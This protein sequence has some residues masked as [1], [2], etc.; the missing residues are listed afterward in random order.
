MSLYFVFIFQNVDD[1]HLTESPIKKIRLSSLSSGTARQDQY[2]NLFD[3]HQNLSNSNAQ[4][5]VVN[6]LAVS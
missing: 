1:A 6:V 4:R 2:T 5:N 3:I